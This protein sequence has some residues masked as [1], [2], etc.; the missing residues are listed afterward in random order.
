M[1][2]FIELSDPIEKLRYF[3]LYN[4]MTIQTFDIIKDDILELLNVERIA[5]EFF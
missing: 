5:T 2:M 4:K 3:C 1:N